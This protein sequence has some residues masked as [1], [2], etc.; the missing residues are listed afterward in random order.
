MKQGL[1]IFQQSVQNIKK[2]FTKLQKKMK[3]LNKYEKVRKLERLRT[4]K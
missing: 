1:K 4:N 2:E 3:E